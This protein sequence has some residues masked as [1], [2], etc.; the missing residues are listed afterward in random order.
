MP[1]WVLPLY[2]VTITKFFH[3]S[4]FEVRMFKTGVMISCMFI[5]LQIKPSFRRFLERYM[6]FDETPDEELEDRRGPSLSTG[7]WNAS[8]P[9]PAIARARNWKMASTPP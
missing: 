9:E 8:T 1:V 4:S 2:V 7:V 6:R 3:H 5:T